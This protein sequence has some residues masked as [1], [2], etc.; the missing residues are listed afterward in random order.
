MSAPPVAT[1]PLPRRRRYRYRRFHSLHLDL[2]LVLLLA[3]AGWVLCPAPHIGV[4]GPRSAPMRVELRR[5]VEATDDDLLHNPAL[6]AF[7][8]PAG[9]SGDGPLPGSDEAAEA[10]TRLPPDPVFGPTDFLPVACPAPSWLGEAGVF[11]CRLPPTPE[12]VRATAPVASHRV[13]QA[14]R[15]TASEPDVA[16]P[17]ASGLAL[18]A[19]A[20]SAIRVHVAF[21]PDGAA[22]AAVLDRNALPPEEAAKLERLAMTARGPAGSTCQL[23]FHVPE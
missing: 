15:C 10:S 2:A 21:G 17:D 19:L 23:V 12:F 11:R 20:G 7:R 13:G 9:F 16:A 3:V 1:P 5:V 8:S 6:F 18:R 14:V 4:R 22:E